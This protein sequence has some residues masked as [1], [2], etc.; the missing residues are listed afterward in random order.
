MK[1]ETDSIIK[2][3]NFLLNYKVNNEDPELI[4]VTIYDECKFLSNNN[5][6]KV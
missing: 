6:Y 1:F 4:V 2:I 5:I 3:K